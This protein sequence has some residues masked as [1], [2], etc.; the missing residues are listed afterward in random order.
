MIDSD[1]LNC[2]QMV[3]IYITFDLWM[4][5]TF[6]KKLKCLVTLVNLAFTSDFHQACKLCCV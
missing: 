4:K 1:F 2:Q 6:K 5:D 3:Y